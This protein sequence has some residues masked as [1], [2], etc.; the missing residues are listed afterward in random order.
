MGI[1]I[2]DLKLTFIEKETMNEYLRQKQQKV[3]QI[4]LGAQSLANKLN[5]TRPRAYAILSKLEEKRILENKERKFILTSYGLQLLNEFE[6]RLKILETF[7]HDE[8]GME[9]SDAFEEA[10]QLVIHVS[11]NFIDILCGKMGK[12][13][14]CPHNYKIPHNK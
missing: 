7:F 11:Y 6:H 5:V 1:V 3:D 4:R 2:E 13:V 10:S 9:L 12:P 8:M 14:A